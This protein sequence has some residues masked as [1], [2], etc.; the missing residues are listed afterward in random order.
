MI[1]HKIIL[2]ALSILIFAGNSH[3]APFT[4]AFRN[5]FQ[6]DSIY[7]FITEGSVE[8][9]KWQRIP[10]NWETGYDQTDMLSASGP[11]ID[12]GERFRVKFSDRGT[13]TLEWAELLN[14]VVMGSGSLFAVNGNFI[15]GNNTFTSQSQIPTPATGSLWL[16]GS[17]LVCLICIRRK[18]TNSDS[19]AL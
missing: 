2:I 15:G 9:D 4:E 8:F 5:D 6:T 3:A 13:F 18:R 11:M 1:H 7:L 16:L 12:P 10:G 17:G 14:G 19:Q